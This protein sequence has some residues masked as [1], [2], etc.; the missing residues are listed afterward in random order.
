MADNLVS[1]RAVL[2]NGSAIT[3]SNDEHSDLFWGLRGAGHNFAILTSFE[4]KIYD[5]TPEN[6]DW[7]VDTM[8]FMADKFD[9]VHNQ[10][11]RLI[12][13]NHPVELIHVIL[14]S[15]IPEIDPDRVRSLCS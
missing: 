12:E 3:V 5:R 9:G 8:I 1:A 11:N 14:W 6:E 10:A 4:S 7:V 13:G 2:A 15:M